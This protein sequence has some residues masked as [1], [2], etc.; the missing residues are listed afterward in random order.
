MNEVFFIN[1]VTEVKMKQIEVEPR[2]YKTVW[3][4]LSN[5]VSKRKFEYFSEELSM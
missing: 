1:Y 5:K 4:I 2:F 3:K